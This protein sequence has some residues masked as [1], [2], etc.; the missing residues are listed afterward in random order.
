MSL[1]KIQP[2]ITR[3]D[4][5]FGGVGAF[6]PSQ[7]AVYADPFAYAHTQQFQMQPGT[8]PGFYPVQ[9]VHQMPGY[10]PQVHMTGYPQA[11]Y[12]PHVAPHIQRVAPY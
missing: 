7:Y 9:V 12:A 8:M 5:N 6:G 3:Y 1:P 2:K 10:P 11:A 4:P